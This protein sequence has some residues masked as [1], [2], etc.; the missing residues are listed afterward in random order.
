MTHSKS[1]ASTPGRLPVEASDKPPVL[2]I[3][4]HEARSIKIY[5]NVE[6][7]QHVEPLPSRIINL[8]G[9]SIMLPVDIR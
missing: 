5:K 3:Y 1:A 4:V 9:S 2:L 6:H 7:V 8:A